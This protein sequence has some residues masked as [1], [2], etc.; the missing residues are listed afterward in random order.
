MHRDVLNPHL[1]AGAVDP[2][3]DLTR[4]AISTFSNIVETTRAGS[5]DQ[6][7]RGAVFDGSPSSAKIRVIRPA[8]AR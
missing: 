3:R 4:L 7:Q 2:E 1:V 5:L 8:A 6:H